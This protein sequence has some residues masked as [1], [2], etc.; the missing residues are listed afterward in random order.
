MQGPPAG[1]R[2]APRSPFRAAAALAF[3]TLLCTGAWMKAARAQDVAWGVDEVVPGIFRFA[4]GAYNTVFIT[5]DAGVIAFD[6]ISPAA[7]P[8]LA[9]EIQRAAP[10][11]PLLAIVYTHH[12]ADHASGADVLR[13]VFGGRVPIIAHEQ[14]LMP[15]LEAADPGLPPPDVT[16]SQRLVLRPGGREVQLLYLGPSHTSSM[17]VGLVPDAGFA[18]AVDFVSNDR[19]G[20]RD[21][22]SHVFPDF[23]RALELLDAL[24]F[25]TIAFGHG[26]VGGHESVRRQIR[27]YVDLRDAVLRAVEAGWSEDE[28]AERVRLPGYEEWGGYSEWFALNVRGVYRWLAGER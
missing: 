4:Y 2:F 18:F 14:A 11:A 28:A 9:Q 25:E 5:T 19:V 26:P 10:G 8:I 7:A 3:G 22:G 16:F 24:E 27:Y 21:L 6:P 23:F 15:L 17:I 12:H 20:Y 1:R 13:A